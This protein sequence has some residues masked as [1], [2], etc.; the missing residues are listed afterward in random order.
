MP[1]T[2]LKTCYAKWRRLLCSKDLTLSFCLAAEAESERLLC[3]ML[4]MARLWRR[5]SLVDSSDVHHCHTT[6]Q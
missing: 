2:D 6:S 4:S 1:L 3:I 5:S